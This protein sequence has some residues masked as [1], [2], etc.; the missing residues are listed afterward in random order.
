M[1]T[2]LLVAFVAL[3][4][5]GVPVAFALGLACATAILVAG[6]IPLAAIPHKMINGISSYIFIAIR[7]FLLAGRLMNA[8]GITDRIFRFARALVGRF[9]GGLAQ[10]NVIAS[11]IFAWMSGSAVATVGGLGEIEVKSM[12]DH[13][14]PVPF[15][16]ALATA[17][18][19]L[20]P[21]IPPSIT[22]IIYG[23]MTEQ[24]IGRLFLGSIVPGLLLGLSLMGLVYGLSRRRNYPRDANPSRTELWRVTR[25]AS[26]PLLMPVAVLGG[27]AGGW[28]TPTEAGA[29]AAVYALVLSVGVY[30]SVKPKD[31]PH[32]LV[33][34]M[35]TTS[36]VTFIISTSSSFSFLLAVEN[37]GERIAGVVL[38]LTTNKYA[39]CCCST[40]SCWDWVP[41]WRPGWC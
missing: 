21:I 31:L 26:W 9:Y 5:F 32:I 40:C 23:A 17:S 34:T 35:I 10:A 11:M 1:L 37:A 27:L 24:S 3:T 36:V 13:G 38:T 39:C 4:L 6:G 16:A 18:S 15:A 41:S 8:G 12:R 14:Y 29:A 33:E 28:F 2:V 7:L 20:G 25:E 22:L 30:R 19:T